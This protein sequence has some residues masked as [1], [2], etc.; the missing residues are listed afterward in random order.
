M[1]LLWEWILLDTESFFTILFSQMQVYGIQSK[2]CETSRNDVTLSL[3]WI[4][5]SAVPLASSGKKG[6]WNSLKPSQE[7]VE[8]SFILE[9]SFDS[10]TQ[11]KPYYFT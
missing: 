5:S 11:K 3:F 2:A 9:Y 10:L 1:D 6:E 8:A 4:W 7:L